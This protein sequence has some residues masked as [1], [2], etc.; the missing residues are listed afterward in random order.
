M[1]KN[2][3]QYGPRLRIIDA[4]LD[5]I[6]H[7]GV[8]GT[9]M[10]VVADKADVSLGSIAYYFNDKD[11]LLAATFSVFAERSVADF[12]SYFTGIH[13]L[14]DARAALSQML[15]AS[16]ASRKTL[17][18]G[19]ELYTLSLRRP[20]HR[21]NLLEWT[22]GCRNVMG[23]FFDAHTT[24]LLDAFYEGLLLHRSMSLGE[25]TEDRINLAITRLTPPESYIGPG[26]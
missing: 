18:L 14:D 8:A 4:T 9:T 2:N 6:V 12:G 15:I 1:P 13:S 22:Q 25:F 21:M 26:A 24:Y 17:I 11:G 7:N 23:Q 10:R 19:T 5:S 20:L 3:P 16:A